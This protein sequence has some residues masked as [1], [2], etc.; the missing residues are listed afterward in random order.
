MPDKLGFDDRKI[1]VVRGPSV[2]LGAGR[3]PGVRPQTGLVAA[4]DDPE[5]PGE[6]GRDVD[7]L[8]RADRR[9]LQ[10]RDPADRAQL[11]AGQVDVGE[12]GAGGIEDLD[13]RRREPHVPEIGLR[14]LELA[15]RAGLET[16]PPASPR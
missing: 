13:R 2:G 7:Q 9:A 8:L 4:D 16:T 6:Q 15:D 12:P 14:E 3:E 5:V 1:G 10:A 11:R